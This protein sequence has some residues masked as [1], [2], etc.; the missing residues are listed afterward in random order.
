M[1]SLRRV[2]FTFTLVVAA[3]PVLRAQRTASPTR[4]GPAVVLIVT[5]G[6]RWQEMFGGADSTHMDKSSGVADT[7]GFRR[8]FWKSTPDER[9]RAIWPFLWSQVTTNGSIWGNSAKGSE[10]VVTNGRKFSYPGYNELLTGFPDSTINSNDDPP[11]R[12]VTVFEWLNKQPGLQGQVMAFGSWDAF[13]RIFNIQRAGFP[14]HS[15]FDPLPKEVIDPML[16]RWYATSTR[17]WGEGMSFDAQMQALVMH[18]VKKHAPRALYVG[19]GETDEW[20]HEKR[21]DLYLQS[22]R[23]VDGFVEELWTT[24]RAM[25]EY[26]DGVTFIVTTDHGRGFGA[27]WTDHGRKVDGAERIWIATFGARSQRLGELT[28]AGRV[29]QGQVASSVA[30]ALGRDYPAAERRA[31][32][33]LT[34][35][36]E[37]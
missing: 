2:L 30:A 1:T 12:N 28:N 14:V 20:A 7:A 32:A 10:A 6:F 33:P 18:Q 25:P 3:V 5:D 15:A 37:H 31:P 34:R 17:P 24:M 4:R 22:A 26:Q 16:R 36:N 27:E 29:T 11:N 19:Y 23:G 9:R 21:Y 13:R 8:M 35:P